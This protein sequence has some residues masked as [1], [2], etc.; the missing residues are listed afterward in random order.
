MTFPSIWESFIRQTSFLKNTLGP[1]G[2]CKFTPRFD[3][4]LREKV[5][6]TLL[7]QQSVSDIRYYLLNSILLGFFPDLDLDR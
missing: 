4:W 6:A 5:K 2:N 7:W 1:G 3:S